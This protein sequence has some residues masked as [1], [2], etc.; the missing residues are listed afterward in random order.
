MLGATPTETNHI[1]DTLITQ[2]KAVNFNNEMSALHPFGKPPMGWMPKD[3][4]MSI[5]RQ[6]DKA[7]RENVAEPTD[8]HI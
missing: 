6:I 8:A 5:V 7:N 4:I 2:E 3:Q 1:P